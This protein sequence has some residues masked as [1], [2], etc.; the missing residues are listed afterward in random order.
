VTCTF[1][2]LAVGLLGLLLCIGPV[3]ADD[4]GAGIFKRVLPDGTVIFSDQPHPDATRVEPRDPQ[5]IPSF[6]PPPR[7][8]AREP[9]PEEFRYQRLA[10][11][12]PLDDEVIW[13]HEGIIEIGVD[14]DPALQPDHRLVVLMDGAIVVD[15]AAGGRFS[16]SNVFRGT[17]ILQAVVEDTAGSALIESEAVTFHLRQ[18]SILSPTRPRQ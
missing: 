9:R 17:H 5:V 8:P 18:H 16:I 13:N 10:I 14:V 12:A 7:P 2:K 3:Y 15:A 11:T 1:R 6:Q 4:A